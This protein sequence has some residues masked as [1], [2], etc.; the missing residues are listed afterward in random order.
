[1]KN[2]KYK[3]CICYATYNRGDVFFHDIS[4]LLVNNKDQRF[5][6]N[7]QDNCSTDGSF[8][9]WDD[10]KD[11]RL[12]VRRNEKNIG[13]I[14]NSRASLSNHPGVEYVMYCID[15]DY[16]NP[17]YLSQ[18]LDYLDEKEP[19][20][21]Y[22]DLYNKVNG[23]A[24]LY[25]KGCEAILNTSYLSRHPSGFFWKTE[26]LENEF[27]QQYFK[28][29][30]PT[31]DFWFDLMTAHFAVKYDGV[32]VKIPVFIQNQYREEYKDGGEKS[33]TYNTDNI[34]FGVP[35][36]LE[37]YSLYIDDLFSLDLTTKDRKFIAYKQTIRTIGLLTFEFRSIL[38]NDTICGHYW[39]QKRKV[40]FLELMQNVRQVLNAYS[41]AMK[42]REPKISI[43]AKSF[44]LYYA[45]AFRLISLIIMKRI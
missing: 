25:K 28:Q 13:A 2:Y 4:T 38:N 19:A 12:T 40:G 41:R 8:E 37:T 21:G 23:E 5:C 42:G 3:L 22:I 26:L 9:K 17:I 44:F 20:F 32:I 27:S 29:T 6:I 36:R 31:F 16:V 14:P 11:D 34:Y 10:I 35:K 30:N 33:L 18:F 45:F 39:L 43:A 24:E 15:K 1:M 7:I